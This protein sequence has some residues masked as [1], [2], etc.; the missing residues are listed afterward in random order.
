M[1]TVEKKPPLL[2]KI[3]QLPL[4][5]LVEY[6]GNPRRGNLGAIKESLAANEQYE[7]IIV[8]ASTRYVLVGN[9]RVQAARELNLPKLAGIVIDVDDDHA[10]R[11]L[12]SSNRISDM[13]GYDDALLIEQLKALSGIDGLD[14]TGYTTDDLDAALEAL[15]SL[16][17]EPVIKAE[18]GQREHRDPGI[19]EVVLLFDTAQFAQV[20]V[21]LGI[22]AKESNLEG[23]SETVFAALKIAAQQLN[24]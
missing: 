6:P 14:G 8:Q 17:A 7:P 5:S 13:G 20:E 12:L 2:R 24:G 4:D 18:R 9:H 21:W 23:T 11:I 1:A 10:R 22:V 16:D 3:E 19:K 15:R